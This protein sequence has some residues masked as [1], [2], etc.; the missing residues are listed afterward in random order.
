MGSIK[1]KVLGL[2]DSIAYNNKGEVIKIPLNDLPVKLPENID[3]KIKGNPLDHQHEWK[4]ITI[5]G[6]TCVRETDTLDTFV[7]PLGTI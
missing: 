4:K 2:S 3:L 5:N 6:E 1:T 7:D